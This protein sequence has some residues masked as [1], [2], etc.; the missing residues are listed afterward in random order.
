MKNLDKF[1]KKIYNGTKFLS[2][3][4]LLDEYKGKSIPDQHISLCFQLIFQSK[5]K[6]LQNKEIENIIKNLELVLT[7]KL[8]AEIR[9]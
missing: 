9:T 1:H 8:N 3:I 6:T 7:D 4:N 2:E 5:E